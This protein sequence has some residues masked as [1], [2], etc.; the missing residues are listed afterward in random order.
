M[1]DRRSG[2]G[3]LLMCLAAIVAAFVGGTYTAA[4]AAVTG[5]GVSTDV[6]VPTGVGASAGGAGTAGVQ[7]VAASVAAHH[8]VL[9][10]DMSG[11]V[12]RWLAEMKLLLKRYLESF[13]RAGDDVTVVVF[14]E[15]QSGGVRE[16]VTLTV[17][18]NGSVAQL[19]AVID[20]LEIGEEGERT[21]TY[22]RP[23]SDWANGFLATR[24][25]KDPVVTVLSD[26]KSDAA[27]DLKKGRI[28]FTE[29]P[30]D[31]FCGTQGSFRAPGM[32]KWKVAIQGG[33]DLDFRTLFKRSFQVSAVNLDGAMES[34]SAINP[35]VLSPEIVM[36]T[37]EELS[38]APPLTNWRTRQGEL[39]MT[40]R[41]ELVEKRGRTFRVE[42]ILGSAIEVIGCVQA[43]IT[44]TPQEFR[45]P[46]QLATDRPLPSEATVQLVVEH[47]GQSLTIGKSAPVLRIRDQG[48]FQAHAL[49]LGSVGLLLA[50][51]LGLLLKLQKAA[52]EMPVF[53]RALGA[54][55]VAVGGSGEEVPIVGPG[56]SGLVIE[57]AA[58]GSVLGFLSR[59]G[60][61][62]RNKVRVRPADGTGANVNGMRVAGSA[63]CTLGH[64]KL[65]LI[66]PNGK[67]HELTLR[68]CTLRDTLMDSLDLYAPSPMGAEAFAFEA[69]RDTPIPGGSVGGNF[70]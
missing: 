42:L 64:S 34:G 70:I 43:T 55:G 38:L 44:R 67:K 12:K 4:G 58:P 37:G 39:V 29:I 25:S 13:V 20:D 22:F 50:L 69:V 36:E 24:V 5:N 27:E 68:A 17:P 6:K 28:S 15:D 45:F 33:A 19:L 40:L 3:I 52:A 48:Y 14:S 66:E 49:L 61:L 32:G 57:E 21:R 47:G 62:G 35:G 16:L 53:V 10:L 59:G 51:G 26:G 31:R 46:V 60:G 8:H 7:S 18:K 54:N 30:F 23:L 56:G 1:S 41:Q 9:C 2:R 63:V 11:S 65:E